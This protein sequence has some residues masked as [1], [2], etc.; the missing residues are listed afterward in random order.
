MLCDMSSHTVCPRLNSGTFIGQWVSF[1]CAPTRNIRKMSNRDA[2]EMIGRLTCMILKSND[3]CSPSAT[4]KKSKHTWGICWW[5]H[6]KSIILC[7]FSLFLFNKR[8]FFPTKDY[9]ETSE[10]LCFCPLLIQISLVTWSEKQ[11]R[12]QN[13]NPQ[14]YLLCGKKRRLFQKTW[15][16]ML[17]SNVSFVALEISCLANHRKDFTLHSPHT[18]THTHT[19]TPL[20]S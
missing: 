3:S 5:D 4:H 19:H 20:W 12:Q 1:I 16:V 2:K 15:I 11:S 17:N 14:W 10:I 7:I 6:L 13:G 8:I 18:H 9:I